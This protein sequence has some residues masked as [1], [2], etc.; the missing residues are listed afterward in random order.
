MSYI[1]AP[2]E[3]RRLRKNASRAAVRASIE[4]DL[5]RMKDRATWLAQNKETVAEQAAREGV[6][7][8]ETFAGY[9]AD[10]GRLMRDGF[11]A[12]DL[13]RVLLVSD[14]SSQLLTSMLS[15]AVQRRRLNLDP[16]RRE[17]L[18]RRLA[19]IADVE[20]A[21]TTYARHVARHAR[22]HRARH[23]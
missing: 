13:N 10:G 5:Q 8:L 6:T 19:H 12:W 11:S 1:P 14:A 4:I 23:V 20:C 16:S 3:H 18:A 7:A 22:A 9:Y 15:T 21:V 17:V 2:R